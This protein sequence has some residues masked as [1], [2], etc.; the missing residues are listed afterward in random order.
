MKPSNSSPLAAALATLQQQMDAA[1]QSSTL[2]REDVALVAASKTQPVELLAEAIGLGITG[3]G[4]NKVQEAAAKWPELKRRYPQVRLHLIGPLQSNK[5]AEAVA[6]FDVIE[7][8]DREKIASAVAAEIKKQGRAVNV[9]I[10]VNTGEE[11]QKGGVKPQELPALLEYCRS[12]GLEISGLM[13]IPPAGLNPAPHFA[14]LKK[15]AD[16]HGLTVLSMGMSDDF[17]AAIRL[18]ASHV[19]IGTRLFGVRQS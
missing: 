6:L 4:E 5:V 8:I 19:R 13:C 16:R 7:T 1:V 14:L 10:Q 17:A 2:A 12:V 3:F 9:L 15:L 18:G 11:P